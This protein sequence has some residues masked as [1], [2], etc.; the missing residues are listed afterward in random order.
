MEQCGKRMDEMSVTLWETNK[1]FL[2]MV[3]M[4]L[5]VLRLGLFLE[6]MVLR[7]VGLRR[8]WRI[9][10]L[11]GECLGVESLMEVIFGLSPEI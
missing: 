4:L 2:K 11:V 8:G 3:E 5:R 9:V 1:E 7:V 6:T 10:C